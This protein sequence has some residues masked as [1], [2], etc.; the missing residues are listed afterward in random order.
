MPIIDW[1]VLSATLLLISIY[2]WWKTRIQS[3]ARTYL[4]GNQNQKGWQVGLAVMATQASA[5]TFIS[6]TGQGYSDGLRFVQFYFGLPLAMILIC[7]F[8]IPRFYNA[9]VLTAYEYLEKKFDLKTRIFAAVIFL[10]QR[11]LAAG[12]T[13]YAPSIIL[14]TV[15]GWN[16]QLT[17]VISGILVI[18]YTVGGGSQ[19]VSITQMHQ[20]MVI[21][22]GMAFAFGY[23]LYQLPDGVGLYHSLQ[24][25]GHFDKVNPVDFNLNFAD[26]YNFW[27][28]ILGGMFVALAYFGTDQSQV[29]R[30]LTGKDIRQSRLGLIFNGLLKVP[31]QIFILLC[32]V[33]L[34]VFMM[35]QEVPLSFNSK[36]IQSM[37]NEAGSTYRNYDLRNKEINANRK[38]ILSTEEKDYNKLNELNQQQN[39]LRSEFAKEAKQLNSNLEVNDRDYIFLHYILNYLP[40][41][42]LGLLIA[43]ILCAA[44]SS[45]SAE[46]NALAGTSYVDIIKRLFPDI[47]IGWSDV[48]W[49]KY[50]TVFWG[51][52]ALGFA[53]YANLFENLIQFINIIGSLFYGS[54]LGIFL[55]AFLFNNVKGTAIFYSAVCSQLLV[56]MLYFLTNIGFLW[57]NVIGAVSV[58]ISST[59]IQFLLNRRIR[60]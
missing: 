9:G 10:I 38:S 33:V 26:R 11:G 21:I 37:S 31:M 3:D 55:S 34:F 49:T 8:F 14:S 54:V 22:V 47:N 7:I 17:H 20:M 43:V 48:Q 24:I 30:Y 36:V 27:S 6:T 53:F 23:M 29:Q 13:L 4:L 60:I 46:L 45:I 32:G 44:M 35:Y 40:R 12:I 57:F 39:E 16:L 25:A 50:L 1:I 19:A 5:I 58:I 18:W 42:L 28:G 56:L 15:F 52:V 51:T 2:G 59:I 41:G